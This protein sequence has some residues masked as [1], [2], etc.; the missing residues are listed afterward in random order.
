MKAIQRIGIL[1]GLVGLTATTVAATRTVTL[2]GLEIGLDSENGGIVSLGYPGMGRIL[3]T[4]AATAGLLDVAFPLAD[5]VPMRLATRF[6][7]ARIDEKPGR[8][9]ISW[10][11]LAPSRTHVKLPAGSAKASVTLTAAPDGRSVLLRCRIENRFSEAIPQI[12]FPDFSGLRPVGPVA[13]ARLTMARGS[14]NPFTLRAESRHR[15]AFWPVDSGWRVYEATA[16]SYGPNVLSWLDYGSL[17]GGFSLFLKKWRDVDCRRPDIL[18]LVTEREPERMRLA[19]WQPGRIG[20]GET[21][22]S[23]DH[24][25]TPHEG[26][27]AKGI[28]A[29]RNYV[30]QV[31]PPHEIPRRVREGLGYVSIW[32]S[33]QQETVPERAEMRFADLPRIARDTKAH[34]LD[35]LVVWRWCH[36]LQLPVPIRDVL[37]TSEEWIGAIREAHGMGVNISG[38][39]GVH[40][41]SHSQLPR[42]GVAYVQRNAWNFHRDLIPNFN[43][44]YLRGLPFDHAGQTVPP[45][46]PLWQDDVV[47]ALTTWIDRG[48]TSFTWDVFG[49]GGPDGPLSSR[50]EDNTALIETAKRFRAAAKKL[51]PQSSFSGETNSITGLEWDGEV[52]DYTWNWISNQ[53]KEGHLTTTT[54]L[55]YI[56]AAPLHNVLRSPRLNTIVQDSPVALKKAFA[57]GAYINFLLRKPDGENGSAILGEKPV[58]SAATREAAARRKQFLPYFTDGLLVG[59]CVLAHPA[60]LF[61]RGHVRGDASMLIV[62]LNDGAAAHRETL[63]LNLALWLKAGTCRLTRYD[64]HG[65]SDGTEDLVVAAGRTVPLKSR[66]LQPGEM[67]FLVIE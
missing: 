43:P 26:G 1:L 57:D 17:H 19:L 4:D 23:A 35:E 56:D 52:M 18:T 22:Q 32:M 27:W 51:D 21:W 12:L 63:E 11:E 60:S 16:Y 40:L 50:Y 7:R 14:V 33:S 10:D 44:S 47:K 5:Y 15:G 34:G 2:N 20:P 24:V 54:Y 39:I 65:A 41:L 29:F 61:V 31:N 53:V 9:T 42:Y 30:A 62:V 28:E 64:E 55:E 8:V 46:N 45:S 38:A 59:D 3:E 67:E 48:L 66:L 58:L 37:G 13:D 25:L 6:S 36:H 49:G